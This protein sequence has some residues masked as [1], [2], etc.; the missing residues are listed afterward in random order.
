MNMRMYIYTYISRLSF[1]PHAENNK[2]VMEADEDSTMSVFDLFLYPGTLMEPNDPGLD[3]PG[4]VIQMDVA[5]MAVRANKPGEALRLSETRTALQLQQVNEP[6][7][8]LQVNEPQQA[9]EVSEPAEEWKSPDLLLALY[10]G[11]V[12]MSS[13]GFLTLQDRRLLF[14]DDDNV[15]CVYYQQWYSELAKKIK[16]IWNGEKSKV[17]TSFSNCE[18]TYEVFGS[19][20]TGKTISGLVLIYEIGMYDDP[21]DILYVCRADE[22]LS[23]TLRSDEKAVAT[24]LYKDGDGNARTYSSSIAFNTFEASEAVAAITKLR[25]PHKRHRKLF[26]LIDSYWPAY[27]LR[28]LHVHSPTVHMCV[29]IASY[30]SRM[31]ALELAASVWPFYDHLLISRI[32]KE[33]YLRFGYECSLLRTKSWIDQTVAS[34]GGSSSICSDSSS[35]AARDLRTELMSYAYDVLGGSARFLLRLGTYR[36][37]NATMLEYLENWFL[38]GANNPTDAIQVAVLH[39]CAEMACCCAEGLRYPNPSRI[40]STRNF[41]SLFLR[42][43][44]SSS[45]DMLCGVRS[46]AASSTMSYVLFELC[47]RRANTEWEVMQAALEFSGTGNLFE[48]TALMH[49]YRHLLSK[50]TLTLKG[51]GKR[52][53]GCSMTVAVGNLGLTLNTVT[54]QNGVGNLSEN[55]FAICVQENSGMFDG[56]CILPPSVRIQSWVD[57]NGEDV[58]LCGDPGTDRYFSGN[59]H[60]MTEWSNGST[61]E[62]HSSAAGSKNTGGQKRAWRGMSMGLQVAAR[63]THKLGRNDAVLD[64]YKDG[65]RQKGFPD[66]FIMLF[67]VTN[68][69]FSKFQVTGEPA[70]SNLLCFKFACESSRKR[71]YSETEQRPVAEYEITTAGTNE[72]NTKRRKR[73]K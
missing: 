37:G 13:S 19:A 3:L 32:S 28:A 59:G 62:S 15:K 69:H 49:L 31:M 21:P 24:L 4:E 56:I 6:Q 18:R 33:D 47:Q 39:A 10:Q 22:N 23:K 64:S 48:S 52:M 17:E 61:P 70:D 50:E 54:V 45:S 71:E 25:S 63:S 67:C 8:V 58:N 26:V 43:V 72:S 27:V 46:V 9:L 2:A 42:Q 41:S 7:L 65:I 34:C 20:G 73:N 38:E 53:N 36:A 30:G 29:Y 68:E 14:A 57:Q 12:S 11:Q 40:L 5:D 44:P 66:L 1:C 51:I 16:A 60:M 35:A 55:N